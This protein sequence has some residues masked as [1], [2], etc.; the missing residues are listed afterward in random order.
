MGTPT[1]ATFG[2]DQTQPTQAAANP[3]ANRNRRD[4]RKFKFETA[5]LIAG[6]FG[7]EDVTSKMIVTIIPI[8]NPPAS[9]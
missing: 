8:V 5:A 4:A 7:V 3:P 1:G 6:S 9:R 2:N